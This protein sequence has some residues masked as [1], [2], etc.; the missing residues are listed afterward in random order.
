MNRLYPTD[1]PAFARR[2]RFAG[3]RLRRVALTNRQGRLDLDVVL[4]ARTA[5]RDLGTD[6]KP[7]RLR[8]RV[9]DVDECRVQKRLG[10]N[11]RLTDVA[12][13]SFGGKVYVNFDAWGLEAGER[14]GVHDFRASDLFAGGRDLFWEEVPRKPAA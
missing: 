5:V 13:G 8:L 11:V 6:P 12:F 9:A 3:A 7:V 14:P 2:F 10:A 1:F 4:V